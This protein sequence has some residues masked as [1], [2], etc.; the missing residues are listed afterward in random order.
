MFALK[1][2]I[3]THRTDTSWTG[4]SYSFID[5][6]M[7][8]FLAAYHIACNLPV[9]DDIIYFYLKRNKSSYL[10]ISKVF[11]FL[12]GMNIFAANKLSGLM[13]ECDV[14]HSKCSSEDSREFQSIIESGIKEAAANRQ[15]GSGLKLSHFYI[16]AKNMREL[17]RIWSTNTSNVLTL[18]FKIFV[19]DPEF[20]ILSSHGPSK[21]EFCYEL[22]L[23]LCH[24]L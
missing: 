6:T 9:I 11:I 12:C 21:P 19:G 22:N 10:D 18:H 15:D 4:S 16:T 20:C 1:A 2:G 8:E 7:Q 14:A 24:K 13:N 23:S 3:L 5:K 17:H